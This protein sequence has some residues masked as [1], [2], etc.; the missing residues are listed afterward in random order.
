MLQH[1]R[2]S[3]SFEEQLLLRTRFPLLLASQTWTQ[4][5][6]RGCVCCL[7]V[8]PNLFKFAL[9]IHS[10]RGEAL[11]MCRNVVCHDGAVQFETIKFHPSHTLCKCNLKSSKLPTSMT[12]ED[13]WGL[14]NTTLLTSSIPHFH[15]DDEEQTLWC[16]TKFI[17]LFMLALDV[18]VCVQSLHF[19]ALCIRVQQLLPFTWSESLSC[20]GPR[21]CTNSRLF[22]L[23]TA[24]VHALKADELLPQANASKLPEM[25]RN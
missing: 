22:K 3:S 19:R 10:K 25:G 21:G 16:Y 18:L 11:R 15:L 2:N 23:W 20:G 14:S 8:L 13:V 9:A 12:C 17:Y 1:K 6:G 4:T 5:N 24:I 7:F